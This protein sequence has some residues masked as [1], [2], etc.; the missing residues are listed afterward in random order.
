MN[1]NCEWVVWYCWSVIQTNK[2]MGYGVVSMVLLG[3]VPFKPLGFATNHCLLIPEAPHF[4][5]QRVLGV[6]WELYMYN[7][8]QGESSVV[9]N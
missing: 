5:S 1:E 2:G 3:H 6:E 7:T 8:S 9:G 4:N